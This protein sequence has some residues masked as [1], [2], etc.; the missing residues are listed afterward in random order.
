MV[1]QNPEATAFWQQMKLMSDPKNFNQYQYVRIIVF[2]AYGDR[3][4]SGTDFST[5]FAFPASYGVQLLFCSEKEANELM[6]EFN[7][8]NETKIQISAEMK[9]R[10]Y[11]ITEGHIGLLSRTLEGIEEKF[12]NKAKYREVNDGEISQYLLSA[13][14][15]SLL[16]TF[17][18]AP[19]LDDLNEKEKAIIDSLLLRDVI[20]LGE[21]GEMRRAALALMKKG[22]IRYYD[23]GKEKNYATSANKICFISLLIRQICFHRLHASPSSITEP[24]TL[25]EF[26]LQ[27]LNRMKPSY[28]KNCLGVGKEDK[29]L[30][31]SWQMEFYRIAT[32]LLPSN[33]FISP[34][35]GHIFGTTGMADFYINDRKKWIIELIREG[36][37]LGAHWGRF[38]PQ[39]NAFFF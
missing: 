23:K 14:F 21:S 11:R 2:A 29:L 32:S 35:V 4:G 34:D 13:S 15:L 37:R 38:Q 36:D 7:N 8:K 27:C 25:E 20:S 19:I 9:K 17:R 39:G 18:A 6:D 26:L 10:L 30:E 22:I 12:K 16:E 3:P 28:L 24:S 31:R 5:P 33:C 1:Y